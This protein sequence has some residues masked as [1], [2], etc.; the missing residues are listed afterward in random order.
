MK[1]ITTI[2]FFVAIL[3]CKI[4][5]EK[6]AVIQACL[7]N[8]HNNPNYG[9]LE[10]SNLFLIANGNTT[11]LKQL[12]FGEQQIHL[13]HLAPK[14]VKLYGSP[15]DVVNNERDLL[16]TK[17]QIA[18]KFAIVILKLANVNQYLRFELH[19]ENSIWEVKHFSI[20]ES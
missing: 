12:N 2:I 1:R 7:N 17:L 15:Q 19:E 10:Q 9:Y 3:G 6:T 16:I 20:S 18:D 14:K 4:K 8:M 11:T 5:P 13:S